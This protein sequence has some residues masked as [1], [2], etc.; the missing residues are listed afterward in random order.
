MAVFD[1]MIGVLVLI[2]TVEG[3]DGYPPSR[4]SWSL[5]GWEIL[6]NI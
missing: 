6:I 4:L 1:L 5:G 2:D 3:L